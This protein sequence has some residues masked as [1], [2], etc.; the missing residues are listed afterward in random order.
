MLQLLQKN[1]KVSGSQGTAVSQHSPEHIK[2]HSSSGRITGHIFIQK[3]EFTGFLLISKESKTSQ[4]WHSISLWHHHDHARLLF[5]FHFM[6]YFK[7]HFRV[8]KHS[9]RNQ[10]LL[11][12]VIHCS[13]QN[14][15]TAKFMLYH[16]VDLSNQHPQ[17]P[18]GISWRFRS[19][20]LGGFQCH[21]IS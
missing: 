10:P 15:Q 6:L 12:R 14:P 18:S 8:S 9:G 13:A 17:I 2:A 20:K 5:K 21:G 16:T 3:A 1:Q 7:F 19:N 4:V 11:L